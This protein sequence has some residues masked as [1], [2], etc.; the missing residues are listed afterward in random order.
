MTLKLSTPC[1]QVLADLVVNWRQACC[2]ED[3]L[4]IEELSTLPKN[5][6]DAETRIV[7]L[8]VCKWHVD[9]GG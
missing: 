6:R 8:D 5:V 4:G 7:F 9:H 1:A 2:L 3:M